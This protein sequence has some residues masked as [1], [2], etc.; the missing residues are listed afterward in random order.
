MCARI[1]DEGLPGVAGVHEEGGAVHGGDADHRA[2][3]CGGLEGLDGP[4]DRHGGAAVGGPDAQAV[5]PVGRGAGLHAPEPH[6][7]V[8]AAAHQHV[9]VWAPRNA[10][11]RVGVALQDG[12]RL[13]QALVALIGPD[14]HLVVGSARCQHV[15]VL[16][17]YL[18]LEDS[19]PDIGKALQRHGGHSLVEG[20]KRRLLL[21]LLA[22][23]QVAGV[24]ADGAVPCAADHVLAVR[25]EGHAPHARGVALQV[26]LAFP[27]S[28]L[29]IQQELGGVAALVNDD[30]LVIRPA[31]HHGAR[32]VK[33]HRRDLFRVEDGVRD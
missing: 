31:G 8:E 17:L 28:R 3:V 16:V 10:G 19:R 33:R 5:E 26:E 15:V 13:P 22:L 7:L 1:G 25:A 9:A 14:T 24:D 12:E 6:G 32:G 11:H 27:G 2:A 23:K 29:G 30:T 4:G 20:V 21:R 18:G